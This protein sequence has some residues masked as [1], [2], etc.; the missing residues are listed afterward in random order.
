MVMVVADPPV[1][2]LIRYSYQWTLLKSIIDPSVVPPV[3]PEIVG[4]PGIDGAPG[5]VGTDVQQQQPENAIEIRNMAT[6][7]GY[8]NFIMSLPKNFK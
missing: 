5:I 6:I 7:A 1:S 8:R 4:T 3:V 2:E